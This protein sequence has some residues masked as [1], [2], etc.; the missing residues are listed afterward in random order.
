MNKPGVYIMKGIAVIFFTAM[1]FSCKD[2]INKVR[3]FDKF[4][5]GPQTEQIGV[6]LVYTDSGKVAAKLRGARMLDFTNLDFP[7]R[8][9]PDGVEVDFYDDQDRL[10]TVVA[11][12]GIIYDDTDLVDLRGNIKIVTGDSTVLLADQLYWDQNKNRN[13]VFTDSK[14]T[15]QM[16]NGTINEGQG[17]DSDDKFN[18]FISRSNIGIHRVEEKEE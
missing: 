14:Y 4:H 16:N 2:R 17:F 10:N 5:M 9:F 18:N 15:I 3:D 12:Y 6:N 8:E 1:L 13:W 11:D 7:F